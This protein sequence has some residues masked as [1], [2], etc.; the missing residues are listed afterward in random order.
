MSLIH[1]WFLEYSKQ[2]RVNSLHLKYSFGTGRLPSLI[3]IL[4]KSNNPTCFEIQLNAFSMTFPICMS[5]TILYIISI[6]RY[7]SIVHHEYYIKTA[8]NKSLK[9]TI[10][11]A[12]LTSF[13][14]ATLDTLLRA[15]HDM[16][17]LSKVCI[18]MS[19]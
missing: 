14:W 4:W 15:K 12:T 9:I 10:V 18:A 1:Y 11:W 8:T 3:Y 17:K 19:A 6:D 16:T 7:I 2:N 5:G 13:I